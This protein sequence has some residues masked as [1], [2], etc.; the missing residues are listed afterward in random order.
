M[1]LALTLKSQ[2]RLILAGAVVRNTGRHT[3]HLLVETP[4][5]V[6]R[7]RDIL[8]EKQAQTPCGRLY[9]VVQLLYLEPAQLETLQRLYLDLARD[10]HSAAPSLS[11]ILEEVSIKVAAGDYYRALQSAKRLMEQEQ[12]LLLRAASQDAARQEFVPSPTPVVEL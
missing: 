3:A 5:T 10:V 11:P 8:P 4:T 9:L 6:L 7:Q 1:A 12:I 2:E